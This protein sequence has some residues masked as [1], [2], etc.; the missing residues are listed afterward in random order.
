MI[1]LSLDVINK[2]QYLFMQRALRDLCLGCPATNEIAIK[3]ALLKLV[4]D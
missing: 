1:Q 3:L 4:T 2:L